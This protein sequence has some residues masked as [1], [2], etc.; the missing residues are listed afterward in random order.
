MTEDAESPREARDAGAGPDAPLPSNS[1]RGV[2]AI[3]GA[4]IWFVLTS[5][6]TQLALPRLF[7]S[8]E[9][10][11]RYAA[12]LAGVSML[13]NVL[14]AATIQTVS[15]HVSEREEAARAVARRAI[16]VQLALGAALAGSLFALA[17]ALAA[18]LLDATLAPLLRVAAAVVLFYAVYASFVG[19]LNGRQRFGLQARLDASF[20]TF[21]TVGILGGA[22]AGLGAFGAVAGWATAAGAIA[23]LG[24]VVAFRELRGSPRGAEAPSLRRWL[25]FLAPI[26]LYHLCLNGLL[27]LD[28]QVLKRTAAELALAAGTAPTEAAAQA[29]ELVG[30]YRAAQTFATVPYQL[31]LAATLVVSRGVPRAPARADAVAAPAAVRTTFRFALLALLAIAAPVAGA[32][33]G[34][35]RIAYPEPYL[36]GSDALV[37]LAFA[38]VAFTLFVIAATVLG[39]AGQPTRAA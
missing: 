12:T 25:A 16:G 15:K 2:V 5:Y 26:G 27:L 18:F 24:G 31:V 6:A 39:G 4:K 13:N 30:F 8:P 11:G 38:M 37:V 3:A 17:P 1:G 14:I 33:D 9:V 28:V 22:A 19:L 36:A 21:R 20:S 34:V 23:V 10:F 29:S 32:A 35:L 7:D